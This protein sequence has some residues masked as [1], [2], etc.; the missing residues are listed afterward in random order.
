MLLGASLALDFRIFTWYI[1]TGDV[2]SLCFNG[3]KALI[4]FNRNIVC[5]EVIIV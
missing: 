1:L 4:F 2:D 3:Y 5:H